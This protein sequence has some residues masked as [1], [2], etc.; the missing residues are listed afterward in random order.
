MPKAILG[1]I[2]MLYLV[3]GTSVL[4]GALTVTTPST[5]IGS[6][7]ASQEAFQFWPCT[8][9]AVNVAPGKPLRTA[10]TSDA[11]YESIWI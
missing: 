5:T 4:K 8:R 1:S 6:N 11:L 2:Q 7:E 10:F 3:R 9:V